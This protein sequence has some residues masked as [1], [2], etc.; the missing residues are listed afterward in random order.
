MDSALTSRLPFEM[1]HRIRHINVASIDSSLFERLVHDFSCRSDERFASDILVIPRLFSNQHDW[2]G[3]GSLA[4]D[5]LRG[6]LVKNDTPCIRA[7]LRE[8]R[9]NSTLAAA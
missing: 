6:A 8:L 1:L 2:R 4:K 3:F 7:K 5:S 9:L